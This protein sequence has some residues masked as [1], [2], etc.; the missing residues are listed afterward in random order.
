MTMLHDHLFLVFFNRNH[1]RSNGGGPS[2]SNPLYTVLPLRSLN[3][4]FTA[5]TFLESS[6]RSTIVMANVFDAC[7]IPLCP[8]DIPPQATTA[9]ECHGVPMGAVATLNRM[10]G[11]TQL[12]SPTS[13]EP[14]P[15]FGSVASKGSTIVCNPT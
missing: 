9:H 13:V 12:T 6:K 1:F 8:M 7:N 14:P 5:S 2:G 3:S 4:A 15:A 11:T 10:V